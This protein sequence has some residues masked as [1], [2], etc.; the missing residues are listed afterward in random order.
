MPK[1]VVINLTYNT[2]IKFVVFD[3]HLFIF[4]II[5]TLHERFWAEFEVKISTNR[6]Q[7]MYR[8]LWQIFLRAVTNSRVSHKEGNSYSTE[9]R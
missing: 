7:I 1:H 2:I 6:R 4:T 5:Y 8:I 9:Y 3:L